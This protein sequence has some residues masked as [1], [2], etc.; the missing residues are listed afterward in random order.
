MHNFIRITTLAVVLIGAV[1]PVSATTP[2]EF[3]GGLLRRGVSSHDAG[4]YSEASKQ[5]RIAA[6][7]LV[8]SIDQYETAQVYL[9]LTYDKLQEPDRA[10]E[11]ARRVV[12]A[13]RVERR[14]AALPLPAAVRSA[15]DA[16]SARLLAPT[17]LAALRSTGPITAPTTTAPLAQRTVTGQTTTPPRRTTTPPQTTTPQTTTPPPA[18]QPAAQPQPR[19]Q[20]Q[21]ARP[22]VST[23][24]QQNTTPE[25]TAPQTIAP[26]PQPEK[27]KPAVP[28]PTPTPVKPPQTAT[29][30]PAKPAPTPQTTTP[31]GGTTETAKPATTNAPAPTPAPQQRTLT[32]SEIAAR[33]ATA[34][35]A[36]NGANL[37]DA[38]RAYRELLAVPTLERDTLIRVAEG[39]YRSRDFAQALTAFS[40]LGT[41]RRGEEPYRYYIAVALYETGDYDRAKKELAAALPFIEITPD[42]ARYRTRIEG[43]S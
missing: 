23:P 30:T 5:L 19:P 27:P 2:Q 39:L 35:K 32:A 11:S 14:Y 38:R 16:L 31:R 40:R 26:A 13:E 20:Q 34:E 9:S 43:A 15:F 8:D 10:R 7:G 24:A 3:Y 6:F 29:T 12:V 33:L 4:R 17:D 28:P 21:P 1:A 18:T 22:P 42:V 36:I 41:L 37:N 25:R